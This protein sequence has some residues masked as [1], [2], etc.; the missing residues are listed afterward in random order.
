[1]LAHQLYLIRYNQSRRDEE[2]NI[3]VADEVDTIVQS[4]FQER[5]NNMFS[6]L[7]GQ[8]A[9]KQETKKFIPENRLEA[10]L[11]DAAN[12]SAAQP[13]FM[14]VLV[15]SDLFILID[16]NQAQYGSFVAKEGD[17]MRFKGANI[18]GEHKIPIFTSERR[19]REFI[20]SQE[21]FA[22]LKGSELFN[23]LKSGDAGAILNPN[24]SYGKLITKN[25][26]VALA[27]GTYFESKQQIL[28]KETKVLIGMPKEYPAKVIDA[29]RNYFRGNHNIK[30][31]YFA[32]IH[33]PDSGEPP[34]L[35]FGIEADGDFIKVTTGLNE[36]FLA[37]LE[38]KFADVVQIGKSNLDNY[39]K[40]Q[41]PFYEK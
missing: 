10:L 20:Q 35:I 33:M 36:V 9:P 5:V 37:S 21:S 13:E 12:N 7:F 27:N 14:K 29:L 11:M 40:N 4:F 28:Q 8:K 34:H 25:E 26:I 2:K 22:R 18:Q 31:A 16:S 24:A 15:E 38:G 23:M 6:K 19:L 39:F 32:Q 30:K 41:Q 3:P 17:T 1:M